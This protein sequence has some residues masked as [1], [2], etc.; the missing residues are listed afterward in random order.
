[1]RR[2][3]A[4][5]SL[6][7][8]QVKHVRTGV[9]Q[10]LIVISVDGFLQQPKH[11]E[12]WWT[13]M[14]SWRFSGGSPLKGYAQLLQ[15]NSHTSDAKALK[16]SKFLDDGVAGP[17]GNHRW[18]KIHGLKNLNPLAA[19]KKCKDSHGKP[20]FLG[21]LG[22]GG[23]WSFPLRLSK[24][25]SPKHLKTFKNYVRCNPIGSCHPSQGSTVKVSLLWVQQLL[26]APKKRAWKSS[27]GSIAEVVTLL[28]T[29]PQKRCLHRWVQGAVWCRRF[30]FY[31]IGFFG[32]MS[33]QYYNIHWSFLI[34][35]QQ[36]WLVVTCPKPMY[37]GI[38]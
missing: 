17:H 26:L 36:G 4:R 3:L 10:E 1:M 19:P 22:E 6:D 31:I 11:E 30:L 34:N 15:N 23:Q 28:G 32:A 2:N 33:L 25:G 5:A 24:V 37:P 35:H 13:L 38:A 14:N 8:P 9:A 7:S 20:C 29:S 16:H 12:W 18:P 27:L 21:R